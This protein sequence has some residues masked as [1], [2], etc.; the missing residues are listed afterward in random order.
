M[1]FTESIKNIYNGVVSLNNEL[2]DKL[3]LDYIMLDVQYGKHLF[4]FKQPIDKRE[5]LIQTKQRIKFINLLLQDAIKRSLAG[6]KEPFDRICHLLEMIPEKQAIESP[7]APETYEDIKLEAH[8][9]AVDLNYDAYQVRMQDP[10]DPALDL[11]THNCGCGI[12]D[13]KPCC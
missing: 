2:H 12:R 1:K 4:S 5:A 6:E 3:S 7:I 13:K 10:N 8:K 11:I 9:K